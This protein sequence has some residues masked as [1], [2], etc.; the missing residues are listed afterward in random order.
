MRFIF[1]EK[2]EKLIRENGRK[3]MV[4]RNQ[5]CPG[6]E[7]LSGVLRGLATESPTAWWLDTADGR[8]FFPHIAWSL[9]PSEHVFLL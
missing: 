7:E 3:T 9:D 8:G 1:H 5:K 2:N 6:L 4:F